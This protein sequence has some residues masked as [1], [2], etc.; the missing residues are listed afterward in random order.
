M[1]APFV[2][3]LAGSILGL[4]YAYVVYPIAVILF[5]RMI[6]RHD[7]PTTSLPSNDRDLPDIT[8]LIAAHNAEMHLAERIE[9]ILACDYPPE[10]LNIVVASDGSTDRT[11]DVVN[12]FNSNR[13]SVLAFT[14]RRGKAATLV[15]A[16]RSVSS[17]VVVFTDATTRFD[18]QSLRRLA[19]H[20]VDPLLG[21]AAGQVTMVDENGAACESAYWKM[22][23]RV[24][25]SEARLG[26]TLG[27]SGAIYA[28][29]RSMF[30]APSRSIIN[31]D[32]VFPMLIQIRHHCRLALDPT[33]RAYA[34]STGGMRSEFLRRQ[35]IGIGAFQCLPTLR[36][37]LSW[38]NRRQAFAFVSHKMLRWSC[39]FLLVAALVSNL[40]LL[41]EPGFQILGSMQLAAY[42][43][44]AY[45]WATS[46]RGR[47]SRLVRL[48]TSFVMMN[49]AI[50]FGIC[51]WMVRPDTVIWNPTHRPSWGNIAS[52]SPTPLA[53]DRRAA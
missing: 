11:C 20:F 15:A 37:L 9:N 41:S 27:A 8:V 1:Y 28:I 36:G 18:E 39:P 22:E 43:I 33:A 48:V 14:Y 16:M 4:V 23:N 32:L 25:R 50:G 51:R 3:I 7:T 44:A 34:T 24:R 5:A 49:A 30:V 21:V 19:R 53:A 47:G 13:V 17:P 6:G 52:S 46:K 45:G 26:I 40:L 2:F 10:R 29:R 31:D 38:E 35:R 42:G 12:A